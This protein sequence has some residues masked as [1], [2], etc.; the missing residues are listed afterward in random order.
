M[1]NEP[2]PTTATVYAVALGSNVTEV[3]RVDGITVLGCDRGR[4]AVRA[5][6][7]FQLEDAAIASTHGMPASS[8]ATRPTPQ[9]D[10][11]ARRSAVQLTPITPSVIGRPLARAS[12][13]YLSKYSH[14]IRTTQ[15]WIYT[16]SINRE[17]QTDPQHEHKHPWRRHAQ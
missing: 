13:E 16:S 1:G 8:M 3:S 7:R 6:V 2:R 12:T 4:H 17:Q 14:A 5:S 9:W 11:A 10:T 15:Q